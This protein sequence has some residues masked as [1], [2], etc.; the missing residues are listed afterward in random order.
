MLGRERAPAKQAGLVSREE[1]AQTD[2]FKEFGHHVSSQTGERI[3]L[4]GGV[5]QSV[6]MARAVAEVVGDDGVVTVKYA[7]GMTRQGPVRAAREHEVEKARG[8]DA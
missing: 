5:D 4:R 1:F 7:D 2:Y 6:G 8:K 3:E